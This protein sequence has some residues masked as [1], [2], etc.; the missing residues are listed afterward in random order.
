[1]VRAGRGED[2]VLG[3]RRH[4]HGRDRVLNRMGG[5]LA[6]QIVCQEGI[7]TPRARVLRGVSR[8]REAKGLRG[9]WRAGATRRRPYGYYPA[10]RGTRAPLSADTATNCA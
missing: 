3:R 6:K 9:L 10:C 5:G 7:V 2:R 8:R 4:A 1:M